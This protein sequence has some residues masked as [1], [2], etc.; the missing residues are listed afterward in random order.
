M[1]FDVAILAGSPFADF[2]AP[3]LT[4]GGLFGFGS[5]AIAAIGIARS[6]IAP[7]AAFAIGCGQMIWIV[8]QLSIIKDVSFLHPTF[9]GVGL[10]IALTAMPWGWPTLQAWRASR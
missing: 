7:F 4:L 10:L 6:R 3:G 8:V 2:T 1:H 9:F 5:F